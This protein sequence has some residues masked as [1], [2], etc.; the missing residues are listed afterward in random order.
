[1]PSSGNSSS[2]EA[3][4]SDDEKEGFDRQPNSSNIMNL[5]SAFNMAASKENELKVLEVLYNGRDQKLARKAE[6]E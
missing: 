6:R 5:S 3:I 2:R 4:E 1:M